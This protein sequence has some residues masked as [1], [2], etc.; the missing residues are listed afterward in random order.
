MGRTAFDPYI[1]STIGGLW[2]CSLGGHA[3]A[4][5]PQ[6]RTATFGVD[7]GAPVTVISLAQEKP[8]ED[9][10]DKY[11]VLEVFLGNTLGDNFFFFSPS[12]LLTLLPS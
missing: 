11:F 4:W 6:L 8:V 3:N 10:G 7:S 1:G 5:N 9:M 2:Q 12:R